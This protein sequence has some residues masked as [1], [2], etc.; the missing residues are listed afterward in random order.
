M[1][2]S[3]LASNILL[4]VIGLIALGG[5]VGTAAAFFS[6]GRSAYRKD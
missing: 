1:I 2:D 4:G 6:M 3:Q 5:V